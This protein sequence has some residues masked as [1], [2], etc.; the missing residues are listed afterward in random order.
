MERIAY[1]LNLDPLDVRLTNLD[2]VKHTDIQELVTSIKIKA[3][4]QARREDVNH[5]NK[6][7]RWKK[8]GLRFSFL[9]WDQ[10]GMTQWDVNMSVYHGDGTVAIVHSGIEM[11]QGVNTKAV[12]IC[13]YFLKIPIDKI[14]IKANDTMISPNSTESAG[15]YTSQYT[16]LGVQRCC[17][18]LLK[19]LEPIRNTMVNPTWEELI[20]KA[21]ESDVDLQVHSY[22]GLRDVQQ[23]SIYGVTLSEVEIDVLTGEMQVLR[24]DLL[25]DA[26][27]SVSPEIDIGQVSSLILFCSRIVSLLALL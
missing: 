9:R 12:Q 3:D 4:Y 20:Q 10:D 24:V 8:R 13:A 11:G 25:Q 7:N 2:I 27:L 21:Y 17:E 23:F 18:E 6:K 19:R 14:T 15:S 16:G 22:V 26:G 1:E 5:F